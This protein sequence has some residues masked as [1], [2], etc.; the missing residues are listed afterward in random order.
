[1]KLKAYLLVAS[2]AFLGIAAETKNAK[3]TEGVNPGDFAPRIQ[4]EGNES[5]IHFQN[6]D[7]R[8]TL[9]NFW[10]AYDAE[11]RARNVKLWNEV[12]KLNASTCK[13]AMYSI[14]F[15]EKTSVFEGTI[16][17]D[18]LD[19]TAQLH[20]GQ[21]SRSDVFKKYRLERGLKNFL[22]N[23]E[24]IIIASNVSPEKLTELCKQI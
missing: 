6:P 20:E 23:D 24:G 22:V 11:S 17:A 10:A 18:K 5:N 9:I 2:V 7:G 4:V 21:G 8:Y 19:G 16:K 13:V 12:N 15:D 1:M 14:S 3:P